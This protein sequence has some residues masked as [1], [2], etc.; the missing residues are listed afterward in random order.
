MK[1]PEQHEWVPFLCGEAS[2]ATRKQLQQHLA[3]CQECAR[4]VAGW[5]RTLGQLDRWTLPRK[6]AANVIAFQPVFKWALA[7]ALALGA[8]IWIGRSTSL[9]GPSAAELQAQVERAV[10]S[11]VAEQLNH[12]LEQAQTAASNEVNLAEAR[13]AQASAL[14]RQ[15]LWQG[16]LQVLSNTRAED[17]RAVQALFHRYEEQHADQYV[18]MRTDLETLASTTDEELRQAR[19]KL[20]QLTAQE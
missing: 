2:A 1:H 10:R 12:A 6:R 11:S 20:V 17:G 15:Q 14:E 18:A 19:L 8:G 4:E 7:A 5:R 16:F 3:Q 9:Q 13:W